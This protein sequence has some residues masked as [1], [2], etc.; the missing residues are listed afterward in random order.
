MSYNVRTYVILWQKIST[1]LRIDV[2][3]SSS[4]AHVVVC[5]PMNG[6]CC[7]CVSLDFSI[8]SVVRLLTVGSFRCCDPEM[9][10]VETEWNSNPVTTASAFTGLD[11][12]RKLQRVRERNVENFI[13]WPLEAIASNIISNG[14]ALSVC[15][16]P[17][18]L[19]CL[20]CQNKNWIGKIVETTRFCIVV[21]QKHWKIHSISHLVAR[22]NFFPFFHRLDLSLSSAYSARILCAHGFNIF[23][24][25]HFLIV[26]ATC[27]FCFEESTVGAV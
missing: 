14:S 4:S 27:A 17:I 1:T 15:R 7:T 5:V 11:N 22:Q 20:K 9:W 8:A 25:T 3:P 2:F 13:E 23:V 10:T 12:K 21:M 26:N 24:C 19:H 16:M 18:L 6:H